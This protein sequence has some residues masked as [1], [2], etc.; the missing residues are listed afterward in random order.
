METVDMNQDACAKCGYLMDAATGV[1]DAAGL[2]PEAGNLSVCLRC[3]N[4]SVFYDAAKGG[5]LR[6]PPT[7]EEQE[8]I[9]ADPVVTQLADR[10]A[11]QWAAMDI[12]S[13]LTNKL[14]DIF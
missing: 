12:P 2:S 4:V 1:A 3:G 10:M 13:D 5:L 6:R 9:D 8:S 14:E 7:P 11:R